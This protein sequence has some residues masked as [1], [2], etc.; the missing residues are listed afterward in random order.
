M[1]QEPREKES[2][3]GA[4]IVLPDR[5]HGCQTCMLACSL[6]HEGECHLGLARLQV[7]KDMARYTFEIRFCRHCPSPD[8]LAACPAGALTRDG[9]GVVIL[10]DA[11]CI[12]CGNCKEACPY[13]AIFYN[14]TADRY[15]KCDLCAGRTEGPLCAAVCPVG[16]IAVGETAAV[17]KEG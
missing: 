12:Q 2:T 9:R 8:C 6:S 4:L 5:C 11:L 15:L 17:K 7:H 3:P 14:E 1:T 13:D 16:A 10:D